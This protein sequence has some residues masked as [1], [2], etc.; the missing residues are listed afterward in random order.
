MF[1]KKLQTT[2]RSSLPVILSEGSHDVN[3]QVCGGVSVFHLRSGSTMFAGNARTQKRD[4]TSLETTQ[5]LRT[6]WFWITPSPWPATGLSRGTVL[7]PSLRVAS[8]RWP[9]VLPSTRTWSSRIFSVLS[10]VELGHVWTPT[11]QTG[12]CGPGWEQSDRKWGGMR[13]SEGDQVCELI[14]ICHVV[15]EKVDQFDLNRLLIQSN[16]QWWMYNLWQTVQVL[17]YYDSELCWS[18]RPPPMT[19]TFLFPVQLPV[20]GR[21][22]ACGSPLQTADWCW[23]TSLPEG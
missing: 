18:T 11:D 1:I 22:P 3:I 19:S 9:R 10:D 5:N 12:A 14:N 8:L 17:G 20:S 6:S 4:W 7:P 15:E 16:N 2:C 23:Q 21:T 13:S